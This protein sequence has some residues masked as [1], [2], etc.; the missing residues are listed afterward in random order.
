MRCHSEGSPPK[1]SVFVFYPG[2]CTVPQPL[3]GSRLILPGNIAG[4]R[5]MEATSNMQGS[6]RKTDAEV[7]VHIQAIQSESEDNLR[8]R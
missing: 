4:R 5:C 7:F 6:G 1:I 3:G 2:T 8:N